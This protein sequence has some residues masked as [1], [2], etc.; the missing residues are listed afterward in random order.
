MV[1]ALISNQ[2]G[3]FRQWCIRKLAI[4]STGV[5][6]STS[7]VLIAEVHKGTCTYALVRCI[8]CL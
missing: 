2:Q 6:V 8:L 1:C 3:V 4:I 7:T 5:V